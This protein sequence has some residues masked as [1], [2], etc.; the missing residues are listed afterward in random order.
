LTE[1]I[2]VTV[3][4]VWSLLLEAHNGRAWEA[5]G[6]PNWREYAQQ[7]FDFSRSQPYRL[8]DQGRVIQALES[9]NSP[10]GEKP[11]EAQAREL[12]PLKDDPEKMSEAWSEAVTESNGKPTAQHVANAVNR[13]TRVHY[14]RA[15]GCDQ[16]FSHP[17]RHC[18]CGQHFT[19]E[20]AGLHRGHA[21]VS[22]EPEKAELEPQRN[23][24]LYTSDSDDWWTPQD[25]I[26]RV[27]TTFDAP[28]DLDPCSN[29]GRP[30]VPAKAHFTVEVDG[31]ARG[32]FG[33]VFMNP[34]Y[35]DALPRWI[36]KLVSS[37]VDGAVDKAIAL[38]PSRTDTR[39]FRSLRPY[40]RCFIF[41]RLKFSKSDN[42]APFPSMAVYLGPDTE[43]FVEAFSPI[44]D[45]FKV[46][47]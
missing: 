5:L 20:N 14:C 8:L 32:W 26:R 39:W 27:E 34:P 16:S 42:S 6:Y 12:A 21:A 31:L 38:V 40:P 3:E 2:R 25:I 4:D 47:E 30:N 43:R 9:V 44:G 23:P 24:G 33:R 15:R 45:V 46:I 22:S 13:I 11:N 1:R 37:F 10:I 28:I 29:L 7:E 17:V 36:D 19:S 35:G 18:A 41:G